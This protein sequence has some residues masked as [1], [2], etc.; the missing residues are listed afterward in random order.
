MPHENFDRGA[1]LD[2]G[3]WSALTDRPPS[4][5]PPG[6][7]GRAGWQ[8]EAAPPT[9][10]AY[11]QGPGRMPSWGAAPPPT[12]SPKKGADLKGK[13]SALA[14]GPLDSL[15]SRQPHWGAGRGRT[16]APQATP[17][18]GRGAP[19]RADPAPAPGAP[20]PAPSPAP[21]PA[22]DPPGGPRGPNGRGFQ[23]GRGR[24]LP[25]QGSSVSGEADRVPRWSSALLP[26]APPRASAAVPL[27]QGPSRHKYP[28]VEALAMY[29]N[30]TSGGRVALPRPRGPGVDPAHPAWIPEGTPRDPSSDTAMMLYLD[31]LAPEEGLAR[32]MAMRQESRG[33]GEGM[34]A[35]E[36][37]AM[38][39]LGWEAG[40]GQGRGRGASESGGGAGRRGDSEDGGRQAGAE[41]KSGWVV[42]GRKGA[43]EEGGAAPGAGPAR[44]EGQG[45]MPTASS[46]ARGEGANAFERTVSLAVSLLVAYVVVT[47][48]LC[49]ASRASRFIR[50][51]RPP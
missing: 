39:E 14:G 48:V 31:E 35:G 10:G 21:G 36:G 40:V 24:A 17:G 23:M 7:H 46:E 6:L 41:R 37:D 45:P 27:G 8:Q 32:R 49:L 44:G 38:G 47:N 43:R 50:N 51:S 11:K 4:R 16:A 15:D 42:L 22:A 25:R 20:A 2:T 3:R 1:S 28:E 33:D 26:S 29:A 12:E 19:T 13:W 30:M 9:P 5:G 18:A 34:G